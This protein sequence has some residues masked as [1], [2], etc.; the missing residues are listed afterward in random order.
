MEL[1][2]ENLYHI[3]VLCHISKEETEF[4]IILFIKILKA[5]KLKVNLSACELGDQQPENMVHI[6]ALLSLQ[7]VGASL[8][9]LGQ[10]L[11]TF[12]LILKINTHTAMSF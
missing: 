4:F 11:Y 9:Q 12:T 2:T 8:V 7:N 3:L 10:F 5:C 1:F 6:T